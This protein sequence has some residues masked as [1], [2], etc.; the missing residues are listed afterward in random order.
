MFKNLQFKAPDAEIS[1]LDTKNVVNADEMFAQCRSA[2]ARG[3]R[4][5]ELDFGQCVSMN[6]AFTSSGV[7]K[8]AFKGSPDKVTYAVDAF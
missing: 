4:I 6:N 7:M 2:Q 5:P 8:I 3:V 1:G